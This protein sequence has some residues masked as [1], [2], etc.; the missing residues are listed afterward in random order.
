LILPLLLAAA[1]LAAPAQPKAAQKQELES[2]QE[3]VRRL[4]TGIRSAR[5]AEASI[6][7]EL[8]RLEK[9]LKLQALEIRLSAM[10]LEKLS[11]HVAEMTVRK[12]SLQG[13]ID[14]RKRRLRHLLSLLPTL[15]TRSPISRLTEDDGEYLAQYREMV[16]RLL[17]TD[18][19]EIL[20]LRKV[21]D[22]V[23]SLNAKLAEDKERLVAHNEDLHEKQAVLELNQK[24]KKDLLSKTRTEQT[25]R[26]R[27]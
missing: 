10:E 25:T 15:E 7:S 27:S 13:S 2:I 18:R 22:E 24:L 11:D 19:A 17:K 3:E 8:G 1:A 20:S 5:E 16:G 4:E 6:S 12:D 26:M 21:L 14:T 23:E 9:L